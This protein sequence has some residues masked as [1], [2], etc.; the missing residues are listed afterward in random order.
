MVAACASMLK[1]PYLTMDI[2]ISVWYISDMDSFLCVHRL[3]NHYF[4]VPEKFPGTEAPTEYTD[5]RQQYF[6]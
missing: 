2:E 4:E 6:L 3:G 5:D 1:F